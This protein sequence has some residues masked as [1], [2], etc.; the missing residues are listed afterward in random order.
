MIPS[1]EDDSV[2]RGIV[3]LLK[4]PHVAK[5]TTHQARSTPVHEGLKKLLEETPFKLL[6]NESCV[7]PVKDSCMNICGLGEYMIG[8]ANP[9]KAFAHYDERY[10]GIILAHNPDTVPLLKN[11]P[12]ELILS[13]HTH[14][15]QINLPWVRSRI[16]LLENPEYARGLYTVD[17]RWLYIN[18]GV[19]SSL[20]FRWFAKPEITKFHLSSAP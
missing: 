8:Q 16:T 9:E 5:S 19:G 20:D 2:I 13:G 14:G 10:P 6:H 3:R 15:C 17:Q 11:Y 1:E 7:I 12:G 4:P 18:R